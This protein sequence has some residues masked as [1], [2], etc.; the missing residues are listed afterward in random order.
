[1]ILG[2][3]AA[4]TAWA[5]ETKAS[6]GVAALTVEALVGHSAVD[7]GP[8]DGRSREVHGIW[9]LAGGD[10]ARADLLDEDKFGSRGGVFG[11]SY[12]HVPGPRWILAASAAVGHGGPNWARRRLD[13]E[14]TRKWLDDSSLLTRLALYRADFDDS[15]S[16]TGLRAALVAYLPG[17]L[18]LEGG[19]IAN[20][21]QP[22]G[23]RSDMPYA[24][25]TLGH[26]GRQYLSLRAS[27]GSEAYQA[28]GAGRQLVDFHSRSLGLQWRRWLAPSWGFMVRGERYRNPSYTR[29]TVDLG[30][31]GSF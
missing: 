29:E 22:G 25:L 28:V 10:V 4:S 17:G 26:E 5:Q 27:D 9:Q 21:S 20:R 14:V 24:S 12:T 13:V 11:L 7:G 8:P 3:V 2:C 1:M 15:R 19:V 6:A 31:F 18:V 16:D 30:L 23:V